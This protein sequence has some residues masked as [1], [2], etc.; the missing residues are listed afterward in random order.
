MGSLM[1]TFIVSFCSVFCFKLFERERELKTKQTDQ[2]VLFTWERM[3]VKWVWMRVGTCV[4]AVVAWQSC[5]GTTCWECIYKGVCWST[6]QSSCTWCL[7]LRYIASKLSSSLVE[8]LSSS[9]FL[10]FCLLTFGEQIIKFLASEAPL[11]LPLPGSR[12]LRLVCSLTVCSVCTAARFM[13]TPDFASFVFLIYFIVSF[14]YL[15]WTKCQKMMNIRG[16]RMLTTSKT[17]AKRLNF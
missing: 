14:C 6:L 15:L 3:W 1:F 16:S 4:G 8:V 2:S 5:A 11:L 12:D 13:P 10:S 17:T 7:S 9:T